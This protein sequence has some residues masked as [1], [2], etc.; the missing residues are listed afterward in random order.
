MAI[1]LGLALTPE[2]HAWTYYL[3]FDNLMLPP[4]PPWQDDTINEGSSVIT[5]IGGTN[6]ALRM[7]SPFHSLPPPPGTHTNY[8]EY[9]VFAF[10][11]YERVGASRFRLVDFSATGKENLL[12]VSIGGV[13]NVFGTNTD[14]RAP[15]ITLVDGHYHVWSYISDEEILDLGPAVTNVFHTAYILARTNGTAQ[16]W[17][18][19]AIV[20]DGQVPVTQDFNGYV[21]FGSGT[22]W[23]TDAG[24]TLDFDWVGVG[25]AS[26]LPA[27]LYITRDAGNVVVS[28]STNNPGFA[29][30]CT[31]NLPS[32][33]W[34]NV[35]NVVSVVADRYTVTNDVAG[36]AK[37]YR[38]FMPPPPPDVVV[39]FD[40]L[41]DGPVPG[42][43]AGLDWSLGVWTVGGP[44]GGITSKNAYQSGASSS[45]TNRIAGG[46]GGA[47]LFKSLRA[48]ANGGWTISLLD[49]NGQMASLVLTAGTAATLTTGWTT[50]SAW[51]DV[52]SSVGWDEVIDDLTYFR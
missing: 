31:T 29:L 45:S 13:T 11:A 35:T 19:G 43:Y 20:F 39:N 23:Q 27:Q 12:S 6:Y 24:T 32:T 42:S 21:E 36:I 37:F 3:D 44:W 1:G 41:P 33:N 49:D 14:G 50:N 18:D 34:V 15:S 26:D 28:W 22:Y 7:D 17:W 8:N 16:V 25:N 9:Y 38:L 40:D 51:V 4:K 52:T 5:N 46:V 47:F 2:A 10:G 30:Q 48:S